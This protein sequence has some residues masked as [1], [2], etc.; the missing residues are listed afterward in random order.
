MSKK[1]RKISLVFIGFLLTL[2]TIV[3]FAEAPEAP[4]QLITENPYKEVKTVEANKNREHAEM[5]IS[6]NKLN[7]KSLTGYKIS[8]MEYYVELPLEEELKE[9]ETYY[10]SKNIEGLPDI[11]TVNGKKIIN[12]LKNFEKYSIETADFNYGI[13]KNIILIDKA[14]NGIK[15]F[16]VSKLNI[17]S[18]EIAKVYRVEKFNIIKIPELQGEM[19]NNNTQIIKLTDELLDEFIK[20]DKQIKIGKTFKDILKSDKKKKSLEGNS[21]NYKLDEDNKQLVID[22]NKFKE[23]K[24]IIFNKN[25]VEKIWKMNTYE[26]F[27]SA[28]GQYKVEITSWDVIKKYLREFNTTSLIFYLGNNGSNN[29][30]KV[31][32][33]TN[34][35]AKTAKFMLPNEFKVITAGSDASIN[36]DGGFQYSSGSYIRKEGGEPV[37]HITNGG[38]LDK[39]LKPIN[40]NGFN[41]D[42]LVDAE[43]FTSFN[44]YILKTGLAIARKLYGYSGTFHHIVMYRMIFGNDSLENIIKKI[45]HYLK[46][47]DLTQQFSWEVRGLSGRTYSD[48]LIVTIKENISEKVGKAKITYKNPLFQGGSGDSGTITEKTFFGRVRISPGESAKMLTG[49]N[50]SI[51]PGGVRNNQYKVIT[52]KNTLIPINEGFVNDS[53]K[54]QIITTIDGFTKKEELVLTTNTMNSKE[55]PLKPVY[56]S[57]GGT[58]SGTFTV[59]V[60][61]PSIKDSNGGVDV[62]IEYWDGKRHHIYI[63]MI[64]PKQKVKNIIEIEIPE[65]DYKV[66]L[67]NNSLPQNLEN[68]ILKGIVYGDLNKPIKIFKFNLKTNNYDLKIL[69]DN[70]AYNTYLLDFKIPKQLELIFLGYDS[71]EYPVKGKIG[72]KSIKN[73]IVINNDPQRYFIAPLY[74]QNREAPTDMTAEFTLDVNLSTIPDLVKRKGGKLYYKNGN[75]IS[76]GKRFEDKFEEIISQLDYTLTHVSKTQGEININLTNPLISGTYAAPLGRIRVYSDSSESTPIMGYLNKDDEII[77]SGIKNNQYK[78]GSI[79]GRYIPAIP[80]EFGGSNLEITFNNGSGERKV[81]KILNINSS[82]SFNGMMGTE[83]YENNGIEVGVDYQE[84]IR[85]K[86]ATDIS[87]RNWDLTAKNIK[88][89]MKHPR[90]ENSFNIKIPEFDGEVYYNKNIA[91]VAPTEVNYPTKTLRGRFIREHSGQMGIKFNVG[92]KDYDLRI[93]GKDNGKTNL[94]LKIPKQVILKVRDDLGVEKEIPFNTEILNLTSGIKDEKLNFYYIYAPNDGINNNSEINATIVLKTLFKN[95]NVSWNYI[96]GENLNLVSIGANSTSGEKNF[97]IIDNVDLKM[98]LANFNET[99][100]VSHVDISQKVYS[101]NGYYGLIQNENKLILKD[102]SR[103]ILETTFEELTKTKK[104]ISEAGINIKYN[105]GSS[106]DINRNQF[107]FEKTKGINYNKTLR[108]EVHTS[109][110]QLLYYIDFNIINKVGFEILPGKGKLDF[111]DFF[112]GDVKKAESLIEFKNPNNANIN[113]SLSPTNNYK[114]FKKGTSISPNTTI[115]L[116]DLQIKDLKKGANSTNNFKISGIA[117]TTKDT[118]PGEYSGELDVIITIVP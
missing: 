98:E 73:A 20:K 34:P 100:D 55:G 1:H 49:S 36:S 85:S 87:L 99:I 3:S 109:N 96:T 6:V 93:L 35:D 40:V 45:D 77:T 62:G 23:L 24:I 9:N 80:N 16:I 79:S 41:R 29:K 48:S 83:Y 118:L 51:L 106:Q 70:P 44:S 14:P 22:N 88:V 25:K 28:P 91:Q 102:G 66:Y 72:V 76:I 46:Y 30:I 7:P 64:Y 81:T 10:I 27:P 113:I 12:N 78:L 26:I 56:F 65:V 116:N 68:K 33:G 104:E 39:N 47:E 59:M 21:L 89:K 8:D 2:L 107:E 4:N 54:V 52:N 90:I 63:E 17:V 105:Y 95:S 37:F 114:M 86:Y 101:R 60:D 117:T 112:P 50:S 42:Y 61:L 43:F 31:T 67:D 97:T 5:K 15:E 57:S 18:G 71:K 19:V 32:S 115:L 11:Y 82:G 69:G 58:V 111:G 53:N 108:L 92:T 84:S 13:S 74:N 94:K 38:R 75:L 103:K 110:G